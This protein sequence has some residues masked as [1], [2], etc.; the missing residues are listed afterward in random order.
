MD[1]LF[2]VFGNL[3]TSPTTGIWVIFNPFALLAVN[4]SVKVMLIRLCS[5]LPFEHDTEDKLPRTGSVPLRLVPGI[6]DG[7][8]WVDRLISFCE[9]FV[10]PWVQR[11]LGTHRRNGG[12]RL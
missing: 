8:V 7:V 9:L 11:L 12:C 2:R 6:L 5:P 10:H 3:S 1:G 4:D